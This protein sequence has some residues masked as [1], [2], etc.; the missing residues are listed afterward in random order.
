MCAG[1]WAAPASG[2]AQRAFAKPGLVSR[3]GSLT[4]LRGAAEDWGSP[5]PAAV[6]SPSP[7]CAAWITST[8]ASSF[9]PQEQLISSPKLPAAVHPGMGH[10]GVP[11]LLRGQEQL[12]CFVFLLIELI[13]PVIARQ[14][15]KKG[16]RT[17]GSCYLCSH[18]ARLQ[19]CL[20]RG[21]R[22]RFLPAPKHSGSL[23]C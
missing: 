2:A 21:G 8:H 14:R 18:A 4:P 9:L 16:C 13:I 17:P 5:T 15:E 3:P 23:H 12:I 10:V 6:T 11:M 19:P 22:C 20:P 7:S 1:P